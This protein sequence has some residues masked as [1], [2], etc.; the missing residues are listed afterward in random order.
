MKRIRGKYLLEVLIFLF[1]LSG[2][3]C[4][5][6]KTQR[7]EEIPSMLNIL[8]N[9]AQ[10]AVEEGA[11]VRGG[12]HAVIEYIENKDPSILSWF[13]D[14]SYELRIGVV[15]DTAVVMVCGQGKPI[16]EDTY[17]D[18]GAPDKDHRNSSIRS[19]EITM[20]ET[21]IKEICHS[22]TE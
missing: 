13:K 3:A 7:I 21:E 5:G 10:V 1:V 14:R 18:P 2:C 8:T 17:C 12:E 11:Y 19:C 15:A 6:I 4:H 20:S 22:Y 9:I 16:Y